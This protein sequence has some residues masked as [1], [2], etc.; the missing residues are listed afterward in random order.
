M[1]KYTL[2]VG[3]LSVDTSTTMNYDIKEL[4]S[5]IVE[6]HGTI[7]W[8]V[9]GCETKGIIFVSLD[10]EDNTKIVCHGS[11]VAGE[12]SGEQL[13]PESYLWVMIDKVEAS[14]RAR[15]LTPE[16]AGNIEKSDFTNMKTEQEAS[17]SHMLEVAERLIA[18][19]AQNN[20]M[21]GVRYGMLLS[22]VMI[23]AIV[24]VVLLCV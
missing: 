23:A 3:Q 14:F 9:M 15:F 11:M 17:Y 10:E 4:M 16:A 20:F 19:T 24:G 6:N 8:E 13:G 7:S 5:K 2:H 18:Q 22:A 21:R 1:S 12:H